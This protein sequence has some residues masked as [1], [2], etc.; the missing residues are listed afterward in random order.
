MPKF[1]KNFGI[2]EMATFLRFWSKARKWKTEVSEAERFPEVSEVFCF[3]GLGISVSYRSV[4]ILSYLPG[5]QP[6]G[7]APKP[8]RENFTP[9]TC[10]N[11]R[12]PYTL[13]H[14][15]PDAKPSQENLTPYTLY[16]QKLHQKA[17]DIIPYTTR[18][19]MQNLPEKT[20]YL[21]PYTCNTFPRKPYT[22]YT[23][24]LIPRKP[25][26]KTPTRKTCKTIRNVFG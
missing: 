3:S 4:W 15:S 6:Q 13:Y 5:N 19:Q 21:I 9:Y 10:K 25:K 2:F 24:F 8:S 23:S 16:L 14:E 1:F 22:T 26:C 20:L 18:T 11:P 17:L 12:K 7:W